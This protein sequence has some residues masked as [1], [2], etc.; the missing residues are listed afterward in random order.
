MCILLQPEDIQF[1][2]SDITVDL[3]YNIISVIDLQ[4]LE[5]LALGQN[6]DQP[7]PNR[8]I[9]LDQNPLMCNCEVYDL[10]RYLEGRIEPEARSLFEIIPGN[11]SCAGPPELRGTAVKQLSSLKIQ[12]SIPRLGDCPHPCT[13]YERPADSALIV[14]CSG[15]N[16]SRSPAN[17]PDPVK[18][19]MS[20]LSPQ[21]I[22]LNQTELRLRG[23]SIAALPPTTAPGYDRVTWLYL[24]QNNIS[25]LE[26]EQVPPHLQV[27]GQL[28]SHLA[29]RFSPEL[30]ISVLLASLQVLELDHNNMMGLS[31]ATLQALSNRTAL[32]RLTLH[33][34]PWQCDCS[35][36]DMLTFL[37]G[38]FTQVYIMH[39]TSNSGAWGSVVV[40]ALHC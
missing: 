38:H 34:N 26:A 1:L 32:H 14:D 31:T 11:L 9:L 30:V 18:F 33:A 5:L 20:V 36:R 22:K 27:S 12:C 21:R 13:C 24:S 29:F 28:A 2:S 16:L 35:A 19:N 25:T 10:L 17:L 3:T 15:L 40:K 7:L 8:R 37:Q 6:Q 23:N 4:R 39:T